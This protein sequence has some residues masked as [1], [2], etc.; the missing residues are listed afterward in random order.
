MTRDG[1]FPSRIV[2][3]DP[4]EMEEARHDNHEEHQKNSLLEAVKPGTKFL[5]PCGKT[6]SR[7]IVLL[8]HFRFGA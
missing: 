8:E 5:M 3:P 4:K 6:I 2:A 1:I 7:L